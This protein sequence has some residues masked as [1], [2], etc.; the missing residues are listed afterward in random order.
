MFSMLPEIWADSLQNNC[1]AI[2]FLIS[3]AMDILLPGKEKN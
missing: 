2:V 3:L 1:V